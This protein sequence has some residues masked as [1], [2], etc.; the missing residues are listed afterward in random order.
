MRRLVPHAGIVADAEAGRPR[1]ARGRAPPA[2]PQGR[3]QAADCGPQ[4]EGSAKVAERIAAVKAE[5]RAAIEKVQPQLAYLDVIRE[6][7]P[8]RRHLRHASS[9]R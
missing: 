8:A 5:A 9:A 4:D 2:G 3:G 7:L 1:A 6:V